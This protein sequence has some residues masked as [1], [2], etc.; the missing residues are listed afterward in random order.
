MPSSPA[1]RDLARALALWLL[2]GLISL[3]VRPAGAAENPGA[4]DAGCAIEA[5]LTE[6]AHFSWIECR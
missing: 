4:A 2:A 1:L 3:F 5:G 6:A